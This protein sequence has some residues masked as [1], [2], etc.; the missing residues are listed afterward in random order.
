MS[1][2]VHDP[3]AYQ[4]GVQCVIMH[5][6]GNTVRSMAESIDPHAPNMVVVGHTSRAPSVSA[7]LCMTASWKV[8]GGSS[9]KAA[10]AASVTRLNGT[11]VLSTCGGGCRD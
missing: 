6:N 2:R 11:D 8:A 10:S 3:S 4:P 9:G 1:P 5:R 7:G